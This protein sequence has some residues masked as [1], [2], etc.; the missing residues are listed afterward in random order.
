MPDVPGY[1]CLVQ[2]CPNASRLEAANVGVVLL[3]PGRNYLS[4]RL[5]A[6]NERIRQFF[7]KEEYDLGQLNALKAGFVSRINRE[8]EFDTLDGFRTFASLQCNLLRMTPPL[9]C[10]VGGHPNETR[11]ALFD[12]LVGERS[13]ATPTKQVRRRVREAF[14]K[15]KLLGTVVRPKFRVRVP[16]FASVRE[17]PF[18]W[19]NGSTNL[20]EPIQFGSGDEL[21]IQQQASRLA[22]EG[23]SL[24][25][26][27]PSDG[28]A[29]YRV[30]VIGDFPK[31]SAAF[32]PMV[33]RLLE[34]HDVDY[35]PLD[36]LGEYVQTVRSTGVAAE[37]EN[38]PAETR[39]LFDS[40]T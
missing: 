22:I 8:R 14:A 6:S 17:F 13:K 20:I 40:E 34:D 5:A 24:A 12:R 32:E 26:I 7:S 29:G 28:S 39:S 1:Y 21:A 3:C 37:R 15:N 9:G 31:A 11:D 18:A 27:E 16:Q 19:Q 38:L 2:F 35:H 33:R 23:K 36:R 10:R 30:D 25:A 4:A